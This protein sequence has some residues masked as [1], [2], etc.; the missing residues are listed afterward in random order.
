MMECPKCHQK[1]GVYLTV[2][3]DGRVRRWRK[4]ACGYRFR[5]CE[6]YVGPIQ[7]DGT[8]GGKR[9]RYRGTGQ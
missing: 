5:T 4:C 1:T 7:G 6:V 2:A 9:T 3:E 8:H